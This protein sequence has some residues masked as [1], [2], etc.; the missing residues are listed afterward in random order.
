MEFQ[1]RDMLWLKK[2]LSPLAYRRTMASCILV[3]V[4]RERLCWPTVSTVPLHQPLVALAS[5][6]QPLDTRLLLVRA[7]GPRK[8][9]I[10]QK[11]FSDPAE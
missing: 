7:A 1:L 4:Q 6:L 2:C 5:P 9:E 3:S 11:G 10:L 8:A